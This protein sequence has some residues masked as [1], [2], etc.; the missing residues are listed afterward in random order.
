MSASRGRLDKLYPGLTAKERAILVLQAWKRDEHEDP[1]VRLTMPDSQGA[2]FNYY[3]DLMNGVHDLTPYV[4]V[5]NQGVAQLGLK[6]AWLSTFDLW[7]LNAS[8]LGDYICFDTKEPITESDH[9][10]RV[11]EA[12]SRA[13]PVAELA[14]VLV[15]RYDGWEEDDLEP[16]EDGDEEREVSDKAWNRVLA[17][18]KKELARLADQGVLEGKRKGRRLLIN[19]G[20]FYDWLGQPVPVFPDWGLEFEVFADDQADE[21]DR[22]RRAR[23]SARDKLRRAPTNAVLRSLGGTAADGSKPAKENPHRIDETVE[24][25]CTTLR[26]MVPARWR[27]MRTAEVVLEEV[28]AEF[29]DEDPLH[30]QVR[31]AL[32]EA[33]RQ[34]EDLVEH[35]QRR[36]GVFDLPE[37]DE[38]ELATLRRAA[39]LAA[40]G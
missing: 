10:R 22:R 29:D 8:I 6:F 32:D 31:D 5:V 30:P 18:K 23:C 39:K 11:E 37:P 14:E 28:A 3:I 12:R 40:D 4:I 1:Q 33:R 25:L 9:K 35:V 27:E 21:V 36:V 15:E 19:V 7:G 13:A 2:Q 26:E 24:A 17:Q 34:L 20:S 16:P 38:E